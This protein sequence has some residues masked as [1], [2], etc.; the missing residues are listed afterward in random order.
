MEEITASARVNMQDMIHRAIGLGQDCLD[1]K[2]LLGHGKFLPWLKELGLSSST[3]ANYMKVA[4]EVTPG[5][6]LES[7]SYSKV[8]ALLAAPAEERE[9]LAEE[10]EDKSA[11]EVRRLIEERNRAAE[12]ANAE[13]TRA[14]AAEADAKKFYSEIARLNTER[15]EMEY[16]LEQM[17][18]DL[19]TAENNR[20]EVEKIVEKVVEKVPEDYEELKRRSAGMLAAA[21]EAEKRAADAEAELEELRANG[22]A[23]EKPAIIRLHEAV[24]TFFASCDLMKYNM[25]DFRRDKRSLSGILTQMEDWCSAMREAMEESTVDAEVAVR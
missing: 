8:L 18:A 11:A 6:R 3:A 25:A 13:T 14:N 10:T 23:A 5:S 9:Q 2:E 20:V 12:A 21:E 4:R 19:L 22:S 24:Q 17:K 15:A 7:L 1:A 16:K